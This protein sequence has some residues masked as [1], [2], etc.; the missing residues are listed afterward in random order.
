MV[1]PQPRRE[2]RGPAAAGNP[3]PV[4][5][6]RQTTP[7]PQSKG[8]RLA[9]ALKAAIEFDVRSTADKHIAIIRRNFNEI[10]KAISIPWRYSGRMRLTA[11]HMRWTAIIAGWGLL[12]F[13]AMRAADGLIGHSSPFT[14]GVVSA[15]F[16]AVG[17][18]L[19]RRY[20]PRPTAPVD[21]RRQRILLV[22]GVGA[23]GAL[24]V[25]GLIAA[26]WIAETYSMPP[27]ACPA[28]SLNNACTSA[29]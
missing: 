1:P 28:G 16:C 29:R 4:R 3:N 25:V 27:V 11:T 5:R 7:T 21:P 6:V 18:L 15:I 17:I 9:R 8:E 26:A 20:G 13:A 12:V 22:S 2:R 24:A 23:A 19:L 10:T 14:P